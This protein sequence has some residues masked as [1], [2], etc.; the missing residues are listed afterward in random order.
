MAL[1]ITVLVFGIAVGALYFMIQKWRVKELARRKRRALLAAGLEE[2][3][4]YDDDGTPATHDDTTGDAAT[5]TTLKPALAEPVVV[6]VMSD[7]ASYTL[8]A[9]L[10][11]L[12]QEA[13]DQEQVYLASCTVVTQAQSAW[14]NDTYLVRR[15]SYYYETSSGDDFNQTVTE[16]TEA[17]LRVASQERQ[18]V[19]GL[20]NIVSI[21]A[22]NSAIA[23]VARALK[24]IE[25][26]KA[27]QLQP[28]IAAARL[29]AQ[30]FVARIKRRVEQHVAAE[31]DL[32]KK[33]KNFRIGGF[34]LSTLPV[35]A[36]HDALIA[37]AVAKLNELHAAR[38][39]LGEFAGTVVSASSAYS[40]ARSDT[41]SAQHTS[42]TATREAFDR[43]YSAT[44][45]PFL[46]LSHKL[47]A[48]RA[49]VEAEQPFAKRV[50]ELCGE[51]AAVNEQL[52]A[53]PK[54]VA[55]QRLIFAR[56]IL[57]AWVNEINSVKSEADAKAKP[58]EFPKERP[59]GKCDPAAAA[60]I[61]TQIAALKDRMASSLT[62]IAA[63]PID[64]LKLRASDCHRASD[65]SKGLDCPEKPNDQDVAKL[66]D[67]LAHWANELLAAHRLQYQEYLGLTE[68]ISQAQ[69]ELDAIGKGFEPLIKLLEQ[70]LSPADFAK[71][72][73]GRL[74][75]QFLVQKLADIR[76]TLNSNKPAVPPPVAQQPAEDDG[77]P[78][79]LEEL[80]GAARSF[81]F[82]VA[83]AAIASQKSKAAM[84]IA[85]PECSLRPVLAN[86]MVDTIDVAALVKEMEAHFVEADEFNRRGS[87]IVAARA[88]ANTARTTRVAKKTERRAALQAS[89]DKAQ[90]MLNVNQ[91]EDLYLATHAAKKLV[92]L[93]TAD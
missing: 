33:L 50:A 36:E 93:F 4:A 5:V 19:D 6:M 9:A 32:R 11:Q 92:G 49:A 13:L 18:I 68:T 52:A 81:C 77:T 70:P 47:Q 79:L 85:A 27:S 10:D 28:D 53:I 69:T 71:I 91:R 86:Q 89:V 42:L 64:R 61:E 46:S 1:L 78:G 56:D 26:Y 30:S 75:H 73:A 16:R 25:S 88:A 80:R 8:T 67:K 29:V 39:R 23:A 59:T 22:L 12:M 40:V 45:K 41:Q 87:E 20:R 57:A 3:P 51:I 74:V 55:S 44:E 76:S 15:N 31:T 62:T 65:N 72:E 63:I 35:L 66:Q 84:E 21:K 7:D 17:A 38:K 82:A 24:K 48:W 34:K 43:C 37:R 60:R 14:D 58:V 83:Q 54:E 2:K 90:A